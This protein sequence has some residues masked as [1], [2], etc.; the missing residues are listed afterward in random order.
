MDKIYIGKSKIQG[1][2]IFAKKDIKKG[3]R[4]GI[5]KGETIRFKIKNKKDSKVGPNRVGIGKDLWIE[6]EK[7]LIYTNHSC[8]PNMGISGRVIFIALRNIK[9][10][11]E[12]TFDYSIQGED[13]F[14]QMKCGCGAKNC[15][16]VICSIQFLPVKTFKKYLPYIPTYFKK[17]YMKYHKI[18]NA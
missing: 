6:T 10:D 15:R 11:E 7:P 9:K 3:E 8:D 1:R 16:K 2:G 14:W 13:K 12:L 17:V 4:V 18:K 5:I